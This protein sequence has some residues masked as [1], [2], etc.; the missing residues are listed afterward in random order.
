MAGVLV[1]I[2][3]GLGVLVVALNLRFFCICRQPWRWLKLFIGIVALGYVLLYVVVALR[4]VQPLYTEWFSSSW[5]RP[6]NTLA[7]AAFASSAVY[8]ERS[9]GDRCDDCP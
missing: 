7:L 3:I 8:T 4:L 2:N 9:K 5:V 1:F 6:L